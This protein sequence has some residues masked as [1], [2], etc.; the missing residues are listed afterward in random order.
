[1]RHKKYDINYLHELATKRNGKCLSDVYVNI[2]TKYL[3]E[4][5]DKHQW[6]A[7][8]SRIQQNHWCPTCGKTNDKAQTEVFDFVRQFHPDALMNVKGL[9]KSKR[10]ELDILIP[11]LKKA[12][13]LDGEGWHSMPGAVER[14]SR[15]DK[16]CL[17][18][19]IQLLRIK[20]TSQW[21]KKNRS[22]GEQL[23]KEFLNV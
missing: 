22:V 23:V 20:Y 8:A 7:I 21:Y 1:M 19:G 4:C 5:S 17:E 12:I 13:E 15:K 9:L 10:F 18:A 14:D 6:E 11:C 3:W 16:E 2:G